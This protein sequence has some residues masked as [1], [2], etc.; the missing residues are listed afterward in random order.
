ARG[1]QRTVIYAASKGEVPGVE[2][3]MFKLFSTELHQRLANA[4]LDILGPDGLLNK[5]D[6]AA[7]A[8]GK[9]EWS[10]RATALDTIGAGSSEIQKN[11][12]ARRGLG[13]PLVM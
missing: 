13:L 7:P 11:I 3:A 1:L 4:A 9:W 5:A 12:I 6:L 2:A 8:A 10:Y